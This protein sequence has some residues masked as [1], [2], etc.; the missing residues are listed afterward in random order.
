MIKIACCQYKIEKF[1]DWDSYTFKIENMVSEVK[2]ANVDIL[3]LPEYSGIEIVFKSFNSDEELFL[4][5]QDILPSYIEFYKNLAQKHHI[6]IQPGTI[7]ERIA[8]NKFVNRAYFFGPNGEYNFQDKLQLTQ[9]EKS[10]KILEHGDKQKIFSTSFGKMGIAICYDSEFPEI[11]RRLVF[12]GASLIL[13][14]SYT[15]TLAGFNRVFLSC[16]A[17]AIENQ[18]YVA[19]SYMVNGVDSGGEL[20]QTFG[21]A[22]VLGPADSGFPD[23]GIIAKGILNQSMIVTAEIDLNSLETVRKNGHVL[24]YEDTKRCISLETEQLEV[25]TVCTKP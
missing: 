7:I 8:D 21:Q 13:V 4:A 17:R 25:V 6:Y 23:D 3:Q 11:V 9:Y 2:K 15:T 1:P 18:C 5:M 12:N 10:C 16:R 19:V 22:A 14:P 20:E 24:N